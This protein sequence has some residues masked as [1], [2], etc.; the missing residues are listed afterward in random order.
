VCGG[1]GPC[2]W[3]LAAAERLSCQCFF[4]EAVL[5]SRGLCAVVGVHGCRALARCPRERTA[6]AQGKRVVAAAAAKRHT[7]VL[8]AEGDVHTWGHRVVTPRRVNLAAPGAAPPPPR[9]AQQA[10]RVF[11]GSRF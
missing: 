9:P 5:K 7:V 11:P 2:A 4:L 3:G 1:A 10:R 8:T 6:G